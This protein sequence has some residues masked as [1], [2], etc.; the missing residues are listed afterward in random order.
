[1]R[2]KI[3]LYPQVSRVVSCD[4]LCAC[5]YNLVIWRTVHG[6]LYI[7]IDVLFMTIRPTEIDPSCRK[8]AGFDI[9]VLLKQGPFVQRMP[10]MHKLLEGLYET[11]GS[12]EL[13]G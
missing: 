3:E 7:R 1:M 6:P 9:H 4:L 10:P 13:Q 11:R 8:T 5:E 2:F 12:S